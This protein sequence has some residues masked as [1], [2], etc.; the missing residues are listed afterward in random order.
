MLSKEDSKRTNNATNENKDSSIES[1]IFKIGPSKD[2]SKI[3]QLK[4]DRKYIPING[5]DKLQANFLNFF[6]NKIKY[7]DSSVNVLSLKNNLNKI[8][9]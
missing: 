9:K 5:V 4:D 1:D 6:E 7:N 2:A 3:G 8:N